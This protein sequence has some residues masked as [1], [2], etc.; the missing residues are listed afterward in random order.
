ML[1]GRFFSSTS[2]KDSSFLI[3]NEKAAETLGI[4]VVDGQKIY[5][6]YDQPSG[7][8][9]QVIGIMKDFNFKSLK[10]PIQPLAIVLGYEVNWEMAIRIKENH[11]EEGIAA[12][13][14]LWKQFAPTAPFEYSLVED[15]FGHKIATE[16]RVAT[17]FMIFTLLAILIACLGLFGLATFTA[18]QQR[19]AIGIRKVLGATDHEIVRMLNMSFLKLVLIANLIAWPFTWWVMSLWLDQ[20]AFRITMPWWIFPMAGAITFIIALFSVSFQALRAASGNPVN[21]LRNE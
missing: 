18:E 13:Q 14:N 5:S 11:L 19:K 4:K 10:D 2:T 12:V 21:S 17:L 6:G 1:Q 9:R 20:F 16:K 7:R 15:N 3:L 8:I